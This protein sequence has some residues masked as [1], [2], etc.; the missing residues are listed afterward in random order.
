M[1]RLNASPSPGRA[2]ILKFGFVPAIFLLAPL[3]PAETLR[4]NLKWPSGLTLGEA[5]FTSELTA[6]GDRYTLDLDASLPAYALVDRY[7]S[8]T[9]AQSCTIQFT[10]ETRHGSKN[11]R[12]QTSVAPDG[13]I[14]RETI[15]G[16]KTDIPAMPCPRD[17][18]ALLTALRKNFAQPAQSV[19]F[20]PGY[21]VRFEAAM[22]ATIT[23]NDKPTPADK[24]ICIITLP[25]TGDYRLELYFLKDQTRTPALIRAP[26]AL[27]IFSMEL[28]R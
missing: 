2:R 25:K 21:P 26:F 4:Y 23:L 9:S 11:T 17:P 12:E 3:L 10:R 6:R 8:G 7:T 24:V 22:S 27:G 1:S 14:T 18:L 16:G 19:L 28:V 20:G 13:T 15:G 5:S